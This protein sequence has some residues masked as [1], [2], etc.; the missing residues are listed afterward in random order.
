MILSYSS[1]QRCIYNQ[2]ENCPTKLQKK[3]DNPSSQVS[4]KT[5]N[6][7]S[8]HKQRTQGFFM[9]FTVKRQSSILIKFPFLSNSIVISPDNSTSY[10]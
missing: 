5:T 3:W 6:K 2:F 1:I 9:K 10:P 4:V 8:L 7:K